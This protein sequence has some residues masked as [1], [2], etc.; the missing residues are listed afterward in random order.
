MKEQYLEKYFI[1]QLCLI[2]YKAILLI[3]FSL[4]HIQGFSFAHQKKSPVEEIIVIC[5][6]H[7][8]IGYTHRVNEVVDYY[9]TEMID[10]ALAL[11]DSSSV[12]P[13]KQQF[14]W[15]LP[16]WVLY[17]I[18]EDWNGQTIERKLKLEKYIKSGKIIPHALP[19][20]LIS[21]ICAPEDITRGLSFAIKLSQ[22]YGLPLPKSGKMTDEPSHTG[23]LATVLAHSGIK[24]MHIGCNWPS[25]FVKVPPLFWWEGPDGSK[26][27][28][29]YSPI[30]GTCFG[31]YPK[32]WTSPNDPTVGAN[33]IPPID[34]PYRIWPAIL[35][36]GDN[37]GVPAPHQI[38]EM[39]REVQAKMPHVKVRM[40]TMDDFYEAIIKENIKLPIIKNE[41]PDTWIHGVMSDPKSMSLLSHT[42]PILTSAEILDTQL[43][44]MGIK[45]IST[46][47]SIATA[48]ENI[49]LFEEHTWGGSSSIRKYGKAFTQLPPQK[50]LG[51]EASWKDKANYIRKASHTVHSLSNHL[52]SC[53]ATEV[54]QDSPSVLVYN[55]LPWKQSGWV[56]TDNHTMYAKDIPPYGYKT[57]PLN[58]LKKNVSSRQSGNIIEN[59]FFRIT[60]DSTKGT[61]SSLIDK[62]THREWVDHQ[63]PIGLG[64]YLNEHFT[65]EQTLRYTMDYQQGRAKEWPHPGMHKPGMISEKEIPYR[66]VSPTNGKLNITCHNHVQTAELTMPANTSQHLPASRLRISLYNDTPYID[67]E[68]TIVN[69]AKDNWPEADWLCLPFQIKNPE[70]NVYR[71]L[72]QFNPVKDIQTGANRHL[73]AIGSGITL[74]EAN[75]EGIAICPL[76]HPLISLDTPGCWKYSTDFIPQ[77]PVVYL[78]LYNNQWN[79]NFRYWFTGTWSSRVRLWT[80]KEGTSANARSLFL[81]T[82]AMEA[83]NPLQAVVCTGKGGGTLPSQYSGIKVS[84]KG[85]AVTAFSKTE[86]GIL[87]RVWEQAGISGEITVTLPPHIKVTQAQPINLRG[88][89][90]GHPIHIKSEK[91]RFE[92]NQ[93]APASFIL[94]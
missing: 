31:L 71:Q 40:G 84:R 89:I 46:T 53:L 78:N 47:D 64:Q 75:G 86:K 51:L 25:G 76:D 73:Y 67:L 13:K 42:R 24:F 15:T 79:T 74:T 83:H 66:A 19:F 80:L 49:L 36:T 41:M 60:I 6:T 23:A 57:F 59:E 32:E 88:E 28:T 14:A 50:Y 45:S 77:K 55:P 94:K 21:D 7:F 70:F 68:I 8:D 69:K 17:K 58:N 44:T 29:L 9:R 12:F 33:L 43:E 10:K 35:V 27:L 2:K 16:S 20:T 63:N 37:S 39:F 87:L 72:G 1:R 48:Y 18:M 85:V 81:T 90:Q 54:K 26:V 92:L 61:I 56:E 5:K 62:K 30:Y 3:L 91:L 38:Q 82:H 65:F 4:L 11:M 34:W 22:K 52:M 93:Y